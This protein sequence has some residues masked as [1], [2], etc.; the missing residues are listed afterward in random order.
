M[1]LARTATALANG[2]ALALTVHTALNLRLLRRPPELPGPVGEPVAVL[3]PLRDE[4]DRVLPCLRAL[5]AVLAREPGAVRLIV[6]DDG[7]SDGTAD[8]ARAELADTAGVQVLTGAPLPA[9]W[10]GKPHACHQLAQAA[11]DAGVLVFLDADVV[12]EPHAVAAAVGLLRTSGLDLISPYPRQLVSGLGQRLVQPLLQW[13]WATTLPLRLAE[14]SP[15]A[16]LSAANGQFLLVDADAYRR[17]GGHAAVRGAVL[18]DL[19][20]LRAVKH[21]GGAGTVVD[22][23]G[24]AT[25]RMYRCWPELVEG[26]SKSLWSALGGR[27]AS[28]AV[29]AGLLFVYVLPPAAALRGA[30]IGLIGYGVGVLGRVLV[31]GRTG[32][33]LLDCVAHPLSVVAFVGLLARSWHAYDRGTLRW[34]GRPVPQPTGVPESNDLLV[35]SL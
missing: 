27:A 24:L 23:T 31:A 2:A 28:A 30:R 33:A 16:S 25:C 14:R 11:G 18:E 1:R 4:A 3:L 13:S 9:G 34:R 26:Y 17:A 35:A 22:G 20:L 12:L 19:A 10:L 15:R 6:L 21:S 5:H 29:A 7:S 32:G 8:L